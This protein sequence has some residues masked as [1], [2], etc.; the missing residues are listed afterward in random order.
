MHRTT[1]LTVAL[2][3]FV[4]ATPLIAA[5]VSHDGAT[6]VLRP[7]HAAY[8]AL[9]DWLVPAQEEKPSEKHGALVIPNGVTDPEEDPEG[10]GLTDPLSSPSNS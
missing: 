10:A 3:L 7:I 8:Q 5:P 9:L 6:E 2:V 1:I 4:G